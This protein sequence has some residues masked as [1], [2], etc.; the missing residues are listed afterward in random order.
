MTQKYYLVRF[1]DDVPLE[2]LEPLMLI[3]RSHP[4]VAEVIPVSDNIDAMDECRVKE[5]QDYNNMLK[6]SGNYDGRPTDELLREVRRL[7]DRNL[8][9]TAGLK[10]N[11]ESNIQL[12]CDNR[13]L[14][15]ELESVK[16]AKQAELEAA[17]T[18]AANWDEALEGA[19]ALEDDEVPEL[20]GIADA[21]LTRPGENLIDKVRSERKS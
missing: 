1:E 7:R 15:Q 17:K 5:I 21:I 8:L 12:S 18:K 9:L 16:A 19:R 20:E 11:A 14:R 6:A 3:I 2:Q 13:K 10:N 4:D